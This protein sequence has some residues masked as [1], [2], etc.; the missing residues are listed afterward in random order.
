MDKKMC[1]VHTMQF[2]SAIK[3][4]EIIT[5]AGKWMELEIIV[6]SEISHPTKISMA[7]FLHS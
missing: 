3:K 1:Y 6:L 2:Y 5:V 7:C 4:N